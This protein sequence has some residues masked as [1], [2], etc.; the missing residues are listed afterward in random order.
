MIV[1]RKT[2]P[3]GSY[4]E[5]ENI[6]LLPNGGELSEINI[7]CRYENHAESEIDE[8][9]NI[10]RKEISNYVSYYIE[11]KEFKNEPIPDYVKT[12]YDNMIRNYH[13]KKTEIYEKYNINP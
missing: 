10:T 12:E 1:F 7:A 2:F 13:I 3:D 6:D 8:L 9:R 4:I 11:R 5:D